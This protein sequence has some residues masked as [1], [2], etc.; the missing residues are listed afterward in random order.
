MLMASVLGWELAR[1]VRRQLKDAFS[2]GEA[3]GRRR[4]VPALRRAVGR[5]RG[6]PAFKLLWPQFK[7]RGGFLGVGVVVM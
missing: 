6:V 3:V 2:R 1:P 4:G 7:M 5:S